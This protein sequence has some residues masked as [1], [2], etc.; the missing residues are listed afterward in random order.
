MTCDLWQDKLD[1]YV[2]NDASQEELASLEAHLRTCPSCAA[3]ALGRLQMKRM[4][5]AAAAARYSPS[6]QFR[7]RLEQSIGANRKPVWAFTWMRLVAV[8]IPLVLIVASVALWMR[9][10]AREQTLA[11]LLDV[12]VATTA[13]ANPVDVISTDRHTVK[14]WFQGKLPFTFNLP[15]L[16][17]SS[18]KLVG[19]RVMYLKHSA[20]AQLLF[21]L[22]N[23]QLS[24]FVFQDQAGMIPLPT[25]ATATR[26]MAFNL[27]TWS[28]GGLRYVVVGDAS[29]ADIHELSELLRVAGRSG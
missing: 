8:A 4:T 27:E 14:P 5:Q 24:V 19:G 23:H 16:Q 6:P 21:E 10:S 2:D 13:S 29:P 9:Y 11:E 28:E 15:E 3:D 17:N 20:G 1:A 18:F 12:H 7:L 26:E 22:R 25:G